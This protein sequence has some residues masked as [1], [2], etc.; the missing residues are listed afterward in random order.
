MAG[1]EVRPHCHV[2][3]DSRKLP[4]AETWLF[5]LCAD[6]GGSG[7]KEERE[8]LETA[9]VRPAPGGRVQGRFRVPRTNA[10]LTLSGH[11]LPTSD[12]PASC[13]MLA[14]LRQAPKAF[15]NQASLSSKNSQGMDEE[16]GVGTGTVTEGDPEISGR[17]MW[18]LGTEGTRNWGGRG[19]A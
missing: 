4:G 2:G 1:A 8:E 11:L 6:P 14:A 19:R 17:G 5:G 9:P 10:T 16:Q 3:V 18:S 13:R 12:S 7:E 15:R